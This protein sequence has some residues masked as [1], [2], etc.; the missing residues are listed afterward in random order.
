MHAPLPPNPM[1][2]S[3]ANTAFARGL[4]W[5]AS[6]WRDGEVV[7]AL[8][9]GAGGAMAT[10]DRGDHGPRMRSLA[11]FNACVGT[12]AGIAASAALAA[13]RRDATDRRALR[14]LDAAKD[15]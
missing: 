14:C 13:L 9:L 4:I 8:A 6:L 2:F 7:D 5:A 12:L 15:G 10:F 11:L 1:S 3:D